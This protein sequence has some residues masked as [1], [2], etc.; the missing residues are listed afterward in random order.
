MLPLDAWI[1]LQ[2]EAYHNY[3]IISNCKE[4]K[5]SVCL[6]ELVN[7]VGKTAFLVHF[8]IIILSNCNNYRCHQGTVVIKELWQTPIWYKKSLF[9]NIFV[10]IWGKWTFT[11]TCSY[12][13]I[14]HTQGTSLVWVTVRTG[15]SMLWFHR[16]REREKFPECILSRKDTCMRTI[17]RDRPTRSPVQLWHHK[18]SFFS[19]SLALLVF[20]FLIF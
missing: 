6:S 11:S 19:S 17:W 12:K 18:S 8:P 20:L 13:R 4:L 15:S 9:S 10:N 14:I 3:R 7:E 16:W 1:F 5:G 2:N